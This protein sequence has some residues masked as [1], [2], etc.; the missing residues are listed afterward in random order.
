MGLDLGFRILPRE[1]YSVPGPI[2]VSII[3]AHRGPAMG[4]WMTIESCQMQLRDTDLNY[5]F[6]IVANGEEKLPEDTLRL[7]YQMSMSGHLGDFIHVTE[8]MSPPSARQ[9][10]TWSAKGKYLFFFDNHCIVE[11]RYFE[12]ALHSFK[13]HDIGVLHST[14][15]FWTGE[16]NWFE[17]RMA[18]KR[19]F[20]VDKCYDTPA[21]EDK[22]Y[23]IGV[24]GHGGFAVTREA[25]D[26]VDGYWMGFKGYAGEEPYFDLKCWMLG[27]PVW[28]DPQVVHRHWSGKRDYNRHYTDE[29]VVN[30]LM[31][32][33]IIGG[34]KWMYDVSDNFMKS[35]R[36]M[37]RDGS[38]PKPIIDLVETAYNRSK[39]RANWLKV[40]SV[41]SFDDCLEHFAANGIRI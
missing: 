37:P 14:T 7:R 33:H 32:A 4:L 19:H 23:Q 40:H 36:L 8:E 21:F 1:K 25:W 10:G 9:V 26:K 29:Y 24:A 34:E 35:T 2:D 38:R 41:R 27:V 20:W 12:R 28:I 15:N 11:P 6:V 13:N 17:Y 16:N 31:A 22:P 30:L 39:E 3:I 5:E 18:F